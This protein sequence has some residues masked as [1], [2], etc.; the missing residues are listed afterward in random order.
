MA[1][2]LFKEARRFHRRMMFA[3]ARAKYEE[4]LISWEHP[5]LRLYLARVL[6]S[7]G[8]PVLAYDNLRLSLRW[9]PG[10]LDADKEQEARA[11]M[12]ALVEKEL[13]AIEIRCD[14]PGAT[15][16]LDGTLWFIGPGTQRRMV[17]PGEHVITARKDGYFTVAKPVVMLAGREASGQLVLSPETIITAPRWPAWLPWATVGA[18]V[19]V[20]AAGSALMWDANNRYELTHLR[21]EIACGPSCAPSGDFQYDASINEGLLAA[22]TLL[23]GGA[24]ALTG[25]V[26]LFMNGPQSYRNEERGDVKIEIR[27]AASPDAAMVTVRFVL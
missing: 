2:A 10:S 14:E 21:N 13:A 8:L 12:R 24:T 3:E 7:I 9:G 23:V 4:A 19:A 27:P 25:V 20:A 1:L 5:D 15:V 11:T 26:M 16:L 22:G 18:G 6:R 17:T